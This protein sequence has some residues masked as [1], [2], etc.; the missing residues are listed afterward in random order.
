MGKINIAK[1]LILAFKMAIG[2]NI[3]IYNTWRNNEV[4]MNIDG[5]AH[6]QEN[7]YEYKLIHI[8][9]IEEEL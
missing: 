2:Y 6:N 4:I 8:D 3:V 1:R 7:G 9:Y 5:S